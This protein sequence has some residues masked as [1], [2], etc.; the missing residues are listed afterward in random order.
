MTFLTS[1]AILRL[2]TSLFALLGCSTVLAA[3]T[4][5][6]R[7][8]APVV[9]VESSDISLAGIWNFALLDK[10]EI[11]GQS[12]AERPPVQLTRTIKVPLNWYLAGIEHAGAALYERKLLVPQERSGQRAFLVFDGVDYEATVWI[13]GQFVGRHTGYFAAFSVDVTKALKYGSEENTISVLVNSPREDSVAWSQWKQ[14]IKGVLS[15]H[16]TRPGGAWSEKGQDANTGGIWAP[17]TLRFSGPVRV[18]SLEITPLLTDDGLTRASAH[19]RV[20]AGSSAAGRLQIKT[21][22]KPANFPGSSIERTYDVEAPADGR[23]ELSLPAHK[24]ALWWPKELGKPNLYTVDLEIW[25]DGKLSDRVSKRFGYRSISFNQ[26]TGEWLINGRRLFLKGT[27]YIAT[28]WLSEMT[29]SGYERDVA[30]MQSAHINSVRVHAHILSVTFYEVADEKGLLV[31]QDFPLQW[32]YS[33][34]PAFHV[35]AIRQ[36]GEM[37]NLLYN[38]PSVF[39]WSMQNEPPWDAWWMKYKYP[40]YDPEQNKVLSGALADAVRKLDASRHTHAFSATGEHLWQ[41]WYSGHWKDFEK[42]T[43]EKLVTEFGA[44]ALPNLPS[45]QRIFGVGAALWPDTEAKMDIWRYHNFQPD[46]TFKN[47]KIPMGKT[48]EEFIFNTQTYQSNLTRAAAEGLRRQKYAPVGAI[49]QFMFVEDWPSV[50][51]GIV[52]YW[53][54]TKPGYS[55][56]KQAYQ[57]VLPSFAGFDPKVKAGASRSYPVWIV[58]DLQQNFEISELAISLATEGT[59]IATASYTATIEADSAKHVVDW[60]TPTLKAGKYRLKAVVKSAGKILGSNDLELTVHD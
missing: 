53:R 10:P 36:A 43:K 34:A 51:W 48:I 33:D 57:P 28:Q 7:A 44:Q 31:W 3:P 29:K 19:L 47:A 4:D 18:A 8:I 49:F 46:E 35:E 23:V 38:H 41:G 9:P 22:I 56:L 60:A 2:L 54:N 21:T 58:N 5:A 13:N 52:D 32:G 37:V 42:P 20:D 24:G 59:V 40:G 26:E 17:V 16:D 55:A 14:L 39:A 27:N 15:H 25:R 12:P 11:L 1:R 6:P 50:N 45:L 30:L